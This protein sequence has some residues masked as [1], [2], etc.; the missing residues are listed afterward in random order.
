MLRKRLSPL[1]TAGG[2]PRNLGQLLAARRSMMRHRQEAGGQ[3]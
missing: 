3:G 2:P 1:P